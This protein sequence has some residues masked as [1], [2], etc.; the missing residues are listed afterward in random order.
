MT[1]KEICKKYGVGTV[2]IDSEDSSVVPFRILEFWDGCARC[3]LVPRSG[4]YTRYI[5]V[6]FMDRFCNYVPVAG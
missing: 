4:K 1:L 6:T 5:T 2:V 3:E